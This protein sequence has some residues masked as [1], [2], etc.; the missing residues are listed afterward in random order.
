VY[1]LNPE[2]RADW[3][4]Y[5]SEMSAYAAHCASTFEVRNLR[6]LVAAVEHLF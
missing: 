2:P 6:Q 5:D 4:T 1:W 3:D